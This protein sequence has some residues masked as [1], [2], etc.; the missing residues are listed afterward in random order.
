MSNR[1]EVQDRQGTMGL[2]QFSTD[3][4]VG[5]MCLYKD[6]CERLQRDHSTDREPGLAA[7]RVVTLGHQVVGELI[8]RMNGEDW[9]WYSDMFKEIGAVT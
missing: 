9:R 3:K 7:L 6:Y 1:N 8:R 4:L 2:D 5:E